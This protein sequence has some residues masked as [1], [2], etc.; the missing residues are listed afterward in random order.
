MENIRIKPKKDLKYVDVAL[1][2]LF[3]FYDVS[4]VTELSEKINVSKKTISTWRTRNSIASIKKKC[5]ELDIYDEIIV[6]T[7]YYFECIKEEKEG[8]EKHYQLS[9]DDF[10][11]KMLVYF[12]VSSIKELSVK[13]GVPPATISKW[14]QRQS[15]SALKKITEELGIYYDIFEYYN[16][17]DITSSYNKW[18]KIE[19][20]KKQCK[21]YDI[22]ITT[23]KNRRL[24]FIFQELEKSI[25]NK[26]LEETLKNILLAAN[27]LFDGLDNNSKSIILSNLEKAIDDFEKK[28]ND[29]Y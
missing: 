24:L 5:I 13:I 29:K 6:K 7:D 1:E 19:K 25:D 20:I 15:I 12:K 4:T 26:E 2:Y 14:K 17:W 10:F 18:E 8:I 16:P 23:I 28:E 9:F 27:P 3:S 22:Q 11:E 21:M